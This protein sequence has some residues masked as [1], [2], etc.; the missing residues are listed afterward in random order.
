VWQP[1]ELLYTC[2]LLTY[3]YRHTEKFVHQLQYVQFEID[4]CQTILTPILLATQLNVENIKDK[5]Y[6]EAW[7]VSQTV[8]IRIKFA[9]HSND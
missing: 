4:G 8:T 1:C 6:L 2:Y 7:I 3:L 5:K 9:S